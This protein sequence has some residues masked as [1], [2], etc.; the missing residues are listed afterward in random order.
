MKGSHLVSKIVFFVFLF[1]LASFALPFYIYLSIYIYILETF[2]SQNDIRSSA[3]WQ[4]FHP[5]TRSLCSLLNPDT[6]ILSTPLCIF[7]HQMHRT[8]QANE[9]QGCQLMLRFPPGEF[10]LE[11]IDFCRVVLSCLDHFLGNKQLTG[12]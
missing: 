6:I 12:K 7:R 9:G 10:P 11:S 8:Q 5:P 2:M 3:Y 4:G 1:A